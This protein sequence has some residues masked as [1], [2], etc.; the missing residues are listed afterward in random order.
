M[1]SELVERIASDASGKIGHSFFYLV[2][3]VAMLSTQS[4]VFSQLPLMNEY[5]LTH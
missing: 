1:L 2:E 5:S 4:D 3:Q